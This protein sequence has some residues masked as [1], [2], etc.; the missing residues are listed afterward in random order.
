M[1]ARNATGSKPLWPRRVPQVP[2]QLQLPLT[3]DRVPPQS[4]PPKPLILSGS[5][6]PP[7]GSD[8]LSDP[9]GEAI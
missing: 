3:T 2:G 9:D 8:A 6:R 1:T 7:S 4:D 5:F